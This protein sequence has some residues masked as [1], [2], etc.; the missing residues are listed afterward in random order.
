MSPVRPL[1]EAAGAL[2]WRERK[3]GLEVV[4]VHRPRYKDW[5]W[6]KGK[7]DPGEPAPVAAVR[8]VAEETGLD[9]ALG[10][11]LPRLEYPL[12]SG[13]RKRVHYW[14][15]QVLDDDA[16]PV[17]ARGPVARAREDEIDDMRWYPAERAMARLTVPMDRIPLQQLLDLHEVGRL[18]SR[19]LVVVRHAQARKRARWSEGEETR[20]LTRHGKTQAAALVPLLAAY[21]VRAVVTSPWERCTRTMRPFARRTDVEPELVEA[22]TEASHADR[23]DRAAAAVRTAAASPAS[24]A[25]CTHRP[26]LPTALDVV[27]ELSTRAAREQLPLHDPLLRPGQVLVAHVVGGAAAPSERTAHKLKVV[28]N[29]IRSATH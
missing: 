15:A 13:A 29:E 11:P 4:L 8:E 17:R 21:G 7:L 14:A 22:L 24:I 25:L 9:V 6:P 5:S 27:R 20:P 16:A 26:V 23:P 1:V 28:A 10:V 12:L 3:G 18:R 19:A 2:V